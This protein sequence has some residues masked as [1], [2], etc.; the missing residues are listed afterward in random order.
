MQGRSI[1]APLNVWPTTGIQDGLVL[2]ADSK[3]EPG[4]NVSGQLK[5]ITTRAVSCRLQ[6]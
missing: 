5:I 6:R 3:M 4:R 1:A 2:P